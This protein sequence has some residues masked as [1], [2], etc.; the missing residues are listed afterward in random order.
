MTRINSILGVWKFRN[1]D[2]QN[3]IKITN[4]LTNPVAHAEEG[5]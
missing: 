1:K 3:P 5:G 4:F 2:I